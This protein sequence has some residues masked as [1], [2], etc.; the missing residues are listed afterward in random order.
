MVDGPTSRRARWLREPPYGLD[1]W[2]IDVANMAGRYRD[3]DVT[4]SVAREVRAAIADA[5]T[6]R[7]SSPSTGTTPAA[8]CWATAGT[9][10]MNYAGFLRPVWAWLRGDD[11]PRTRDGFLGLPVG[12]PRSRRSAT[13]SRRCARSAPA[14]R[15]GRCSHSWTLL[16]SHDTARFRTVVGSTASGRSSAS[17]CR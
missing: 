12:V 7:C 3:L 11:A 15:G 1:G 10:T 2:R 4:S 16:D 9:A 8:T 6:T 17:G 14:S 5:R 13:R